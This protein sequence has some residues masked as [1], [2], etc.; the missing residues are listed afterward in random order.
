M[1]IVGDTHVK[2][3]CGVCG[4]PIS[5]LLTGLPKVPG[6]G[7]QVCTKC[8]C[9]VCSDHIKNSVCLKCSGGKD[10]C[11]TPSIPDLMK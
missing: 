7:T 8:G 2:G 6:F 11:G 1:S 3:T 4:K 5:S 9:E 10:W